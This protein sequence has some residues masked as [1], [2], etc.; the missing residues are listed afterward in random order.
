MYNLLM[1]G[2]KGHWDSSR[3]EALVD[4]DRFLEHTHA[5]FREKFAT[6]TDDQIAELTSYPVLFTYEFLAN[7]DASADGAAPVSRIGKILAIRRLQRQ[8]EIRFDYDPAIPPI[9]E[10]MIREMANDLDISVRN[11]E[12]YRTHWALKDVDLIDVLK[13]RGLPTGAPQTSAEVVAQLRMLNV[14]APAQGTP[15]PKVFVVHGRED[16]I[17]SEVAHWLSRSGLDDIIL[18]QQPNLGRTIITKFQEVAADA[19]FAVVIMT[20]DDVGGL[21]SAEMAARARQNV[22]FELGFFIGKL[23]PSRVAALVVGDVEKPSDF[24]GVVYIA[25]DKRGG[26]KFDLAR[27]FKAL[28]IPFDPL[29]GL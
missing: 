21:K 11:G 22:I 8:M 23:G 28:R 17:K 3:G 7:I 6:L 9:P 27:E 18:H 10:A 20:P 29:G 13:A 16:G 24:D 26:W 15:K 25:Y 2:L 1:H 5:S 12:N 4:N 14:D 19:A